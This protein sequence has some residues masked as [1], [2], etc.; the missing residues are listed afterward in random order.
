M[1][2][3]SAVHIVLAEPLSPAH[4]AVAVAAAAA[5]GSLAA[6]QI[7]LLDGSGNCCGVP[8]Y[9]FVDMVAVESRCKE[10]TQVAEA[11]AV[12]ILAAGS[13]VVSTLV[14]GVADILAVA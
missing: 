4:L 6:Y 13:L 7:R 2:S 1:C 10:G 8:G 3:I 11:S 5:A 12:D 9:C 14:M